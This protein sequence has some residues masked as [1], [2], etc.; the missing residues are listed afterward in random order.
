MIQEENEKRE[1]EMREE[2]PEIKKGRGVLNLKCH[3]SG[4]SKGR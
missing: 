3:Q 2:V 4:T 1:E